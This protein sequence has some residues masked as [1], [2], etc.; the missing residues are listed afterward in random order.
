M[1]SASCWSNLC[2]WLVWDTKKEMLNILVVLSMQ[3]QLIWTEAFE[4][5]KSAL[6][7]A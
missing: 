7:G 5:I 4:L 1:F 2:D 3:L 6:R